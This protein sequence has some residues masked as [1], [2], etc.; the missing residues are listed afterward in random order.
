[1]SKIKTTIY[2]KFTVG[3]ASCITVAVM[4][5]S[6]HAKD[7][8]S[9]HDESVARQVNLQDISQKAVKELHDHVDKQIIKDF[10]KVFSDNSMLTSRNRDELAAAFEEDPGLWAR[11]S[12]KMLLWRAYLTLS[13]SRFA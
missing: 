5:V 3:L 2:Q 11:F 6:V 9:Y 7:V 1:M 4:L 13:L 10:T 12:H 8:A